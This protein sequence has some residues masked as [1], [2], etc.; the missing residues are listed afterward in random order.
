M[1]FALLSV[2]MLCFLVDSEG[3]L[4]KYPIV[5]YYTPNKMT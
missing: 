3:Y 2:R 5:E 4:N 1:P